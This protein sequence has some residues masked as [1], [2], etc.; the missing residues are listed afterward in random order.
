MPEP[1]VELG[2]GE[3][4][5]AEP[6]ELIYRQI[7][8]HLL[9]P[10][11][12][13]ATHAYTGEKSSGGRPSYARSSIV[14]AQ[15]SRDWHSR[16]ARRTGREQSLA[17]RALSVGEVITARRYIVDDSGAPLPEGE[18]RAPGHCYVNAVGLD[19]AALKSLRASLW[20]A[21]NQRGEIETHETLED[22]ELDLSTPRKLMT[23]ASGLHLR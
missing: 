22:G 21:A 15:D 4:L 20:T 16:H 1:D 8:K 6:D 9:D 17:V 13:I 10:S 2:D 3:N 23:R 19:R 5:V 18:E 14:T 12:A 11:G 7:T